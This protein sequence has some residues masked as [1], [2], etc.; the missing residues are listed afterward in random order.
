MA[1]RHFI[2]C[3]ARALQVNFEALAGLGGDSLCPAH[4]FV[5]VA[6][7]PN[8]VRE[9]LVVDD[10]GVYPQHVR[11]SYVSP[12]AH[13]ASNPSRTSSTLAASPTPPSPRL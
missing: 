2:A 5:S 8:V 12:F 11:R 13:K 4:A 7:L 9:D 3:P 10:I 6:G 1:G